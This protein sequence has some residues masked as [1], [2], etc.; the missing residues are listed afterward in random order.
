MT[1]KFSRRSILSR[2]A[3][4]TAAAV[5]PAVATPFSGAEP[6]PIFAA[7]ERHRE[8]MRAYTVVTPLTDIMAYEQTL[9][10]GKPWPWPFAPE[11]PESDDEIER[12]N[13]GL[14]DAQRDV[15]TIVPTTLAGIAALLDHLS[16]PTFPEDVRCGGNPLILE[17]AF[18][19]GDE[20]RDA[21]QDMLQTTA[22]MLREF[23]S[24][25]RR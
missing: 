2:A 6:D 17:D 8:A 19:S 13:D 23:A 4:G 15:F 1:D 11:T 16:L 24:N 25:D 18:L 3:A 21:A 7:I 10:A 9:A 20:V 22:A 5:L 14:E 12:L